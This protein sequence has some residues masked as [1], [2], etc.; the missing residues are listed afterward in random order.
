M[1]K[2][3]ATLPLLIALTACSDSNVGGLFQLKELPPEAAQ[4]ITAMTFDAGAPITVHGRATTLQFPLPPAPG[5]LAV[6]PAGAEKYVFSTASTKDMAK[7]GFSRFSMKPGEDLVV[8][9]VLAQGSQKVAGFTVARADT[10]TKSDGAKVF[11]RGALP[12]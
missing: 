10:I 5:L 6:Q 11:D 8:T 9:G 2:T 4:T 1:K 12:Q 7:Q 3:L